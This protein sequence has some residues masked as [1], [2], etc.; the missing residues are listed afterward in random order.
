MKRLEIIEWGIRH[1]SRQD[2]T[3]V[4]IRTLLALCWFA[5]DMGVVTELKQSDISACAGVNRVAVNRAI[6][7]LERA[8]LIGKRG[9]GRRV[10][11]TYVLKVEQAE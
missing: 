11:S 7:S 9:Q 1:M 10:A 8:G 4:E 2:L 6:A 3:G 5:D